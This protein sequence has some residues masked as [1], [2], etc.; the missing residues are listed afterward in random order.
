MGN[1]N[2]IDANS[3]FNNYESAAKLFKPALTPYGL[4]Q[5]GA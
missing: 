2:S 3:D 1:S 5:C 4:N